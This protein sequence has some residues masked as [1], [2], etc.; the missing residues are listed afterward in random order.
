MQNKA[1]FEANRP[2][3]MYNRF[4]HFGGI[5]S[6]PSRRITSPFSMELSIMCRTSLANSGGR[7]RR[8]GNGTDAPRLSCNGCGI[9]LSS[10]VAK[11]PGAML[12]TRIPKAANSR[13]AGKVSP[14]MP[15]FEA[16]SAAVWL[17]G[18]AA[19]AFGLGLIAEDIPEML[20]G[21]YRAFLG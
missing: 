2:I 5:R 10:G 3:P 17:H 13:A 11:R 1:N 4:I 15:A 9:P 19:R 21:V 6:A 20:P 14:T 8:E 16:A 7:P 18:E 12:H